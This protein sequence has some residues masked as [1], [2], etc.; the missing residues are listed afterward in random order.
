[1]SIIE[2]ASRKGDEFTAYV[3]CKDGLLDRLQR[4]YE[5]A[6]ERFPL[7]R[8]ALHFDVEP[9]GSSTSKLKLSGIE[10]TRHKGESLFWAE[11]RVTDANFYSLDNEAR[12]RAL[13]ALVEAF[14][15]HLGKE[16]SRRNPQDVALV[17]E[18]KKRTAQVL[19]EH[20]STGFEKPVARTAWY[21]PSL[22]VL[23]AGINSL[24]KRFVKG[25]HGKR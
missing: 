3:H 9:D 15:E 25:K 21:E 7:D 13:Y 11:C 12:W 5:E 6:M 19:A 18:L 4:R 17:A 20:E 16:F 10:L 23:F 14:L 2:Q 24:T 8:V 1:M 22:Y